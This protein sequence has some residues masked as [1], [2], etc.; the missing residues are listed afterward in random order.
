MN[1][2]VYCVYGGDR[3]MRETL[4]SILSAIHCE[5]RPNKDWRLI[6]YT[7]DPRPFA[8][9]DAVVEPLNAQRLN[10]WAGRAGYNPRRKIFAL[11]HSLRNYGPSVLV[12]SDTYFLKPP[13][14]LFRRIEAGN[15]IMHLREGRLGR[16][17]HMRPFCE[18]LCAAPFQVSGRS[19]EFTPNWL[20][21]NSGVVGMDPADE[22]LLELVLTL[23]DAIHQ[24]SPKWWWGEQVGFAR[25]LEGTTHLREADDI[26]YHYWPEH[27]RTQ[28]E[29][30][31]LKRLTGPL[32]GNLK[33]LSDSLYPLRPRAGLTDRMKVRLKR[34]LFKA[35]WTGVG[36]RSSVS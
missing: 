28:F 36:L 27:M 16:P 33:E 32:K 12:D 10:E 5:N 25:V 26:V 14:K 22:H 13:W 9:F 35:G 3:Y 20:V 15:A 11:R 4:F 24:R 30:V 21:W 19:Y 34:L 29:G 31:L 7:D 8:S 1:N 18:S 23:T 6:I 17:P 2:L